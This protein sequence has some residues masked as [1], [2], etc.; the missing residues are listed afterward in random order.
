[1]YFPSFRQDKQKYNCL[2]TYIHVYFAVKIIL[3]LLIIKKYC[4]L[5]TIIRF[6]NAIYV[7]APSAK[8]QGQTSL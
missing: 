6:T 8:Y 4:F 3:I 7:V 5:S 2:I 1:M